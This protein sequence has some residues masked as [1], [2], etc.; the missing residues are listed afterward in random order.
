MHIRERDIEHDV[1]VVA[2]SYGILCL[3]QRPIEGGYPDRL[4]LLPVGIPVFIEFKRPGEEPTERQLYRLNDL[5]RHNTIAGWT[6]SFDAAACFLETLMGATRLPKGCDCQGAFPGWVR[7]LFRP[8]TRE[9]LNLSR[10]LQTLEA[11][12]VSAP[13]ARYYTQATH[14]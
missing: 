14:V 9:D 1:N 3:K 12:G 10:Y 4:Y 13:D 7:A 8:G 11:A 6:D 2:A 5:L